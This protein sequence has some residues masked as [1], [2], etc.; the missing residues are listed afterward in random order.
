VKFNPTRLSIARKR[1]MLNKKALADLIGVEPHTIVRWERCQTEPTPENVFA[2]ARDLQYPRDF[3]FGPDID[4]PDSEY[5]SFRSQTSMSAAERDA[6]LA[7]GQIGFLISDWVGERFELPELKLPDLHL[8]DPESAA[9]ALRQEWGL[10]EKP[11][12]NM[13]RLLE[14][15]GVRVFSLAE[16]T[17]HV[18]AYSL[19]RKG[20][21]Y[22]FLNTVKSA[23]SSRFDAAHE[24]AH[25]VLHQDGSVSGRAAEDQA[26]R[27]ASAFLMPRAD[28]VSVLPRVRHLQQL[29]DKK[30]RWRVSL[31]ALNYRVHKLGIISEWKN[32]D[33]CIEIARRGYNKD[34]PK[35]IEREKSVVWEKV[36]KSLWAENTT[37]LDIADQINLPISEVSD[38]LFG[39]L[40]RVVAGNAIQSGPFSVVSD[41]EDG[42]TEASA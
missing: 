29:I 6:A 38:L 28:V 31:A 26:N 11:V 16:N 32:R 27:F 15:K 9:Q 20:F 37:H 1:R 10:G 33:F 14:S 25:L 30:S 36:L 17:T 22:V 8:Y 18:N 21:P 5:T 7:A 3:F 39:V 41:K 35:G 2:I 23:E 19:W 34:E 42:Q 40:N 12:S 4:E 24:L 13:I